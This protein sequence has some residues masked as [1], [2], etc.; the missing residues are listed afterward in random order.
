MTPWML[1]NAPVLAVLYLAD[2]VIPFILLGSFASW[3]Y[4]IAT[5]DRAPLYQSLPLPAE[6]LAAT[7][8]ILG[9]AAAM[10]TISLSIRFARHFAYRSGDLLHMPAFMLI[11]T[12]LLIPVRVVG[13][14]RMAH[15]AGWGTRSTGSTRRWRWNPLVLVP[16]LL[17][18]VMLAASVVVSV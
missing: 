6:G 14:L 16:Y 18:G 3:G 13:F 17:G 7:A 4:A 5:G 8:M 15:N 1:A 11:N 12:F 2:I 10:T 9:L